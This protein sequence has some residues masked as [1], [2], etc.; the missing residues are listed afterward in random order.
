MK[1]RRIFILYILLGCVLCLANPALAAPTTVSYVYDKLNRLTKVQYGDGSYIEYHYDEVGNFLTVT[2]Y[3]DFDG[4]G[5]PNYVDNCPNL[6]NSS[7]SDFNGNGIGDVCDNS[8]FDNDGLSDTAELALGTSFTNPDSDNDGIHD[9]QEI[10]GNTN[11]LIPNN[12][13]FALSGSYHGGAIFDNRLSVPGYP[14]TKME[15]LTFNGSVVG[16]YSVVSTSNHTP[17]LSGNVW[18]LPNPDHTFTIDGT[19]YTGITANDQNIEVLGKTYLYGTDNFLALQINGKEGVGMS[20]ASL[21]GYYAFSDLRNKDVSQLRTMATRQLSLTFDG[22]GSADYTITADSDGA[23]DPG[24]TTTTYAVGDNGAIDLFGNTGFISPDGEIIVSVDSSADFYT[25]VDKEISLGLGVRRG[26]NM[27]KGDL[28]GEFVAYDMGYCDGSAWTSRA[29]YTFSGNGAGT[30]R[31]TADSDGQFSNNVERFTYDVDAS[32]NTS[33]NGNTIGVLSSNGEY[34][35][36]SDTDWNNDISCISMG[37]G[38][39]SGKIVTENDFSDRPGCYRQGDWYLDMNN[40]GTWEPGTDFYGLFGAAGMTPIAGYWNGDGHTKIGVYNAGSWYF[41]MNGNGLWDGEPIDRMV[42]TWGG[43]PDDIPVV[44]DW[45]GDGITEIGIY[46]S[47]IYTWYLDYDGDTIY[48]PA[49]DISQANGFAGCI[50]VV[51]DWSGNGRDK[52]G[53]YFDGQWYLDANG[54]FA[55]DG[56]PADTFVVSFGVAGM[57]PVVGDWNGS[58]ID[59]IGCYFNGDWYLDLNGNGDWNETTDKHLGA[60]GVSDMTPLVGRW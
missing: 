5:V 48:D 31:R 22:N 20:A 14:V 17:L 4:D 55:W 28:V 2:T 23:V 56:S 44:G 15:E 6:S 18:V 35:L 49:V 1:M 12:G 50:P 26:A 24:T 47:S 36:L 57:L 58:G 40:N 16:S 32:G 10:A 27:D 34:L 45:N 59:R 3:G 37:L 41:D 11:P 21:Q 7:Q 60:Y 25:F 52:I 29:V 19:G 33:I 43:E 9:G 8:D 13:A 54:N 42:N 38:I 51:G 46:R 30:F 39:K 53:V